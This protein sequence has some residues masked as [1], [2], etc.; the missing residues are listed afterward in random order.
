MKAISIL[1]AKGGVGK[2][3]LSIL[4]ATCLTRMGYKV[5]VVDTDPQGS[6]SN[7]ANGSESFDIIEASTEKEIYSIR[8]RLK[9]YHFAIIDGAAAISSLSAA[10]VMVSEL[11]LIPT[12]A[13]PLDFSACGA[14][15]AVIE[16]RQEL[17]PV[18]ARFVITKR[19]HNAKMTQTLKEAIEGTGI[20][21][22][23]SGTTHRQDY[24]KGLMDGQTI[25]DL[26]SSPVRGEID[27]L[28]AE[29][30]ELVQ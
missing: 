11:V 15:L 4:I 17:S 30:L 29:I 13:S 24:V 3:T 26:K 22:L 23:R 14:I 7:W 27:N 25:Y 28:T 5:C 18:E 6:V 9:Q 2:T 21:V 1:N 10:A 8:K 19:V 16:A 20:Q 12:T